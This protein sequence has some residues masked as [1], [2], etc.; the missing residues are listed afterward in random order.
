MKRRALQTTT[1]FLIGLFIVSFFNIAN[2]MSLYAQEAQESNSSMEVLRPKIEYK[3]GDLVDPFQPMQLPREE[4]EKKP[5][6]EPKAVEQP[7]PEV[8]PA[9][10]SIPT[11]K[12]QGLILGGSFPQAII[13]NKIVKIGDTIEGAVIENIEKD[14]I[15]LIFEKRQFSISTPST[16][17]NV[18]KKT[19]GVQDEKR[20]FNAPAMPSVR[21][22]G[23]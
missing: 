15:T 6:S 12:T 16:E 13:N 9:E 18:S 20:Q 5:V 2:L 10:L 11:L 22:G 3:A 7:K 14:K 21:A 4:E 8:K 17:P 19:Q 1:I 23:V